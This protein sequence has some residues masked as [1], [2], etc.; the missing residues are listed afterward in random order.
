MDRPN[1]DGLKRVLRF[2]R[3]AYFKANL[4]IDLR[5]LKF[6]PVRD[7][8]EDSTPFVLNEK[9]AALLLSMGHC[10]RSSFLVFLHCVFLISLITTFLGMPMAMIYQQRITPPKLSS[11]LRQSSEQDAAHHLCQN[12][13]AFLCVPMAVRN[14]YRRKL[15]STASFP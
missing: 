4:I 10:S 2:L 1:V 5:H 15:M 12:P 11:V 14:G 13:D 3:R 6:R 7:M 8:A 9:V